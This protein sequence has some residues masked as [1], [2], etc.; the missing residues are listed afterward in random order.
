MSGRFSEHFFSME[1]KE[2]NRGKIAKTGRNNNKSRNWPKI[3]RK[4]GKNYKNGKI[5]V[6]I[7]ENM[8][9]KIPKNGRKSI[10]MEKN[11]EKP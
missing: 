2:K 1:Q 7:E 10:K 11:C 3:D 8:M 6:E 4:Q 9:G 5:M